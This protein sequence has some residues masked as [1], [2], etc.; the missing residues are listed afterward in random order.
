M[1]RFLANIAARAM[2]QAPI[3]QPRPLS[4][5]EDNT[6]GVPFRNPNSIGE[7]ENLEQVT[8][9]D[10]SNGKVESRDTFSAIESTSPPGKPNPASGF[11]QPLSAG[12]GIPEIETSV[13]SHSQESF[14]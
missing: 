3:V 6:L 5:H 9:I 13:K 1:S 7:N 8:E 2:G 10:L 11:L 4:R 14:P 12:P